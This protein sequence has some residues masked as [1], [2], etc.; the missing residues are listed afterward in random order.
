MTDPARL[1]GLDHVVIA[2]SDLERAIADYCALGFTVEPGGSHPGRTSHNA[3]VAFNLARSGFT[4]AQDVLEAIA[5]RVGFR[6]VAFVYEPIA[7][8]HHYEQ[9]VQHEELAMIADIGGGTSD[10]SIVRVGPRQRG[11]AD[12]AG[13]VLANAFKGTRTRFCVVSFTSDWLYPTRESREIVHALNAVAANVSFV[14]IESNK[15]HDAFLLEEPE[16]FA[17][18]RG[19]INAAAVKH[20]LARPGEQV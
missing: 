7:A 5:R 13:D 3:L 16:F 8:A 4:A 18:I 10:F 2:V 19:F 15:G 20:G 11:K 17:T 12:R 14:E 1:I 9:T 6:D